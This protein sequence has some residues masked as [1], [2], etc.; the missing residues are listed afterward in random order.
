MALVE[1]VPN[2]SEGRR[3]DIIEDIRAAIAAEGVHILD[4]SSD[5]DH[6]RTV[7]TLAGEPEAVVRGMFRGAQVAVSR[8]N[9]DEHLGVHPRIGAVDVVPFIPLR[10]ATLQDCI[11]LAEELGQQVGDELR[12]PVY[13]YEAAARRP[14]RVNL[15]DVRRGGYEALKANIEID[16]LRA[17][18]FGP[19]RVG[20]AGA[21]IIGAR[22]PL[23][24]F[25]VYLDTKN[26]EIAQEIALAIRESGGGLPYL[27]AL[28]LF[29]A[30]QAQVSMN[31]VDY[32]RTSLHTIM[33]ALR[34]E[35]DKRGVI[36]T[37]SELIG[38][39]PHAALIDYAIE[40]LRLPA[41]ARLQT[42][43]HRLGLATGDYR[44][45]QFE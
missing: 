8:I 44:E 42:L 15:A 36:I 30:G 5:I 33:T 28:G 41:Q 45:I 13:L 43:E 1:C 24:A 26:V 37:R 9:L 18:D 20:G 3:L 17:P 35:A 23:I 22:G 4:V 12:I 39:I 14:D 29:V 38:L 19:A 11:R 25:N 32:R 2:F 40:S 21:M 27:K 31:I 10:G 6:N 7:M 34:A 16:P